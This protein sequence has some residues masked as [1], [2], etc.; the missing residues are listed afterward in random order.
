[1]KSKTEQTFP[2]RVTKGAVSVKIYKG[3]NRGKDLFTLVYQSPSGRQ[4]QFFRSLDDAKT[5]ANAKLDAMAK[6][7]LEALRLTGRDRQ[8]HVAAVEALAPT[9]ISLDIAAREFALAFDILG[10]DGI[11]EAARFYKKHVESDLPDITVVEA[12]ARFTEAK[13]SEGMSAMYLKDV[14]G[15]LGRFG[16]AFNGNHLKAILADELRAYIAG[17]KVGSIS[18]NNH[19]RL[20]TGLFNFAREHNWLR[21]NETTAAEALKGIKIKPRDVEIYTPDEMAR[22]IS[23]A[24]EKFLPALA[25]IA[26]GGVRREELTK[27]L[28]WEDINFTTSSL[29]VPA[30]IAKTGRKRKITM[31]DNLKA[32]LAPYQGRKGGIFTIDPRKSMAKVAK[33]AKVDWKRN[34]LRHSFCSYRLEATQSAGQVALEAGNSAGIIMRHYAE[35]V[36]AEAAKQ[37]WSIMPVALGKVTPMPKAAGAGC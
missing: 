36:S 28:K 9:G 17:L 11:I 12:V 31:A 27:G 20:I 5:E 10:H 23:A 2:M 13:I 22:L 8:L 24:S 32:W 30:A 16:K 34:A 21:Q 26:F 14:R 18:K 1:M 15:L 29:I 33:A 7:D 6:G 4:R 19:L 35:V 25:L 37:Y 3:Q